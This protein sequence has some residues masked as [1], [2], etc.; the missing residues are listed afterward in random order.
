[1]VIRLWK[2][3][4]HYN[5]K[6]SLPKN[7]LILHITIGGFF[8]SVYLL[9]WIYRNKWYRLFSPKLQC[10]NFWFSLRSSTFLFLRGLGESLEV[11]FLVDFLEKTGAKKSGSFELGGVIRILGYSSTSEELRKYWWSD[12]KNIALDSN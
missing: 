1:M 10:P 4:K 5:T 11:D 9:I 3:I 6:Q 7:N 2:N 12:S 8:I